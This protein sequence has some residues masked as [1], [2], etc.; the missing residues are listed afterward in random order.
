MKEASSFS[1]AKFQ[2]TGKRS[3]GCGKFLML[4]TIPCAIA[5]FARLC[6]LGVR[7]C[8]KLKENSEPA[9]GEARSAKQKGKTSYK[10][11]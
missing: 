5:D 10:C 6:K 2:K 1:G 9:K 11:P 8:F 3:K 7:L 4:I